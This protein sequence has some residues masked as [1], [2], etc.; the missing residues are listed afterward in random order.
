MMKLPHSGWIGGFLLGALLN[1]ALIPMRSISFGHHQSQQERLLN[2]NLDEM[3]EEELE[4]DALFV[5]CIVLGLITVTI[6]FEWGKHKLEESVTDDMEPIIEKLFGEMT[7][8]G[9]LSMVSFIMNSCG[10]F[11]FLSKHLF[12]SDDEEEELL[13]MFE[14]VHF[15]IF[16]IMI[17]FFVQVVVLIRQ[18]LKTEQQWL[19][20]D[21]DYRR[22]EAE[23]YQQD[24]GA[25][26][27]ALR[28]SWRKLRHSN[29]YISLLPHLR[30]E[31]REL[32]VDRAFFKALRDE[33]ILD[34][35]LEPPFAP[36]SESQRL[37]YDF[38][39]GRYLGLCLV[40]F[41]ARVVDVTNTT[42][43]LLAMG[44]VLMFAWSLVVEED[45][46]ILAWSWLAV[47][48]ISFLFNVFFE[49]H[50]LNVRREL[51]PEG[52][53]HLVP[54][55]NSMSSGEKETAFK[56]IS[57]NDLTLPGWCSVNL[58]QY[59]TKRSWIKKVCVGGKPNRQDTLYWMDR[60]GP[61]L[62][63]IILQVNMLFIGID[64]ALQIVFFLPTMHELASTT[65][66]V[67][68]LILVILAAVGN[69]LNKKH[70]IAT[71]AVICSIGSYRNIPA[72]ADVFREE[73]T[74]NLVRCFLI[75]Y[76][77][78]RFAFDVQ[79]D[80]KPI[81]KDDDEHFKK[82]LD[83]LE[84]MEVSKTFKCF[85]QDDGFIY[86]QEFAD[87]MTTLGGDITEET[88]KKMMGSMDVDAD[89]KVEED[90]F[91]QW[92]SDNMVGRQ[93]D[94]NALR[95]APRVLFQLFDQ[96]NQG[97]LSVSQF[98][99]KLDAL[100]V[101]FN[102]DEQV[103]IINEIDRNGSGTITQY[104]FELLFRKFPPNEL[105]RKDGQFEYYPGELCAIATCH[106][107]D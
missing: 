21:K 12:G 73:K 81:S 49:Q 47:S 77:L 70:L 10:F 100:R 67:T 13:E 17:F 51:V 62:Y 24:T 30:S 78:R 94:D 83:P 35:S 22:P 63:L 98:K 46:I 84:I 40:R 36:V 52:S 38:V 79:Y 48:W 74:E 42:L 88:L 65:M 7:V 90:E 71:L 23:Q 53:P 57:D 18:A 87:L 85:A 27:N 91:L 9:F 34:R 101:G 29:A 93:G 28:R 32:E 92:Y 56:A 16:F 61:T 96:D 64:C 66:F 99:S 3:E 4:F 50:I 15:G 102:V 75:I 103:A 55:F 2:S 105:L 106:A 60:L 8:L 95:N 59:L 43:I 31:K 72:I 107:F 26:D 44:T 11:H 86:M 20:L 41:L 25:N 33:F 80:P 104:E 69:M 1:V 6:A 68:Y 82:K 14:W 89:G 37:K 45:P 19:S 97:E 58:D 54:L 76:R 39:F 5:T